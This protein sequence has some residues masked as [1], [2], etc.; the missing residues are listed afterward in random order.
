MG[1]L[2]PSQKALTARAEQLE[3]K[4]SQHRTRAE[5]LDRDGKFMH[6]NGER[7]IADRCDKKA[8]KFRA[9]MQ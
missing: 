2:Q 8:K 1:F 6:A 9:K 5:Q 7:G 3:H 4:A